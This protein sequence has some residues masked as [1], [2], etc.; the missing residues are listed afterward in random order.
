[1]SKVWLI[2]DA[3]SA[4]GLLLTRS[5]LA[6]E[7]AVIAI[8]ADAQQLR[9]TLGAQYGDATDLYPLEIDWRDQWQIV[10]AVEKGIQRFGGIDV[11]INNIQAACL[12]YFEAL[13]AEDY[14]NAFSAHVL[15]TIHLT[16]A[17]LPCMRAQRYGQV[18]NFGASETQTDMPGCTAVNA[19]GFAVEGLSRSLAEEVRPFGVFVSCIK[20][21]V[22][23]INQ[24]ALDGAEHWLTDY[25]DAPAYPD[26][27]VCNTD[28]E[29]IEPPLLGCA[30]KTLVAMAAPPSLFCV[31]PAHEIIEAPGEPDQ[32][33]TSS[34]R[35]PACSFSNE[36]V[37][38]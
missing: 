7:Q 14:Q 16:Q 3:D 13:R 36:Y 6:A 26:Q 22:S 8:T 30:I 38:I 37:Y 11:L 20:P 5:A 28:N 25:L 18:I 21:Q 12:G 24:P 29:P 4:L 31:P 9:C 2:G 17:A 15:A 19:T 1:M 10:G 33:L 27:A 32:D 34:G 23:G 35:N